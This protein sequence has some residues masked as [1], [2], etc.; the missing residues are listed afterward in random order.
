[1]EAQSPVVPS[2]ALLQDSGP[3]DRVCEVTRPRGRSAHR[4]GAREDLADVL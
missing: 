1:M 4:S 3:E 2:T